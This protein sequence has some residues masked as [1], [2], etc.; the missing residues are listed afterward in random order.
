VTLPKPKAVI[1]DWD[2]TIIESWGLTLQALNKALTAMG[3]TPWSDAE[4]RRR[5]G[6]SARDLFQQ[7]FGE[8]WQEADKIFFE[9]LQYMFKKNMP[10]YPGAE[11]IFKALAAR[12]IYMAVVSNKR[13]PLLRSEAAQAKFDRYF[14][15][16][17]GAGDAAADKPDPAPVHMALEGSGIAP[18]MDVWFVGDSHTDMLC[19]ANAG[20]AAILL[21]TKTP[22]EEM[23]AKNPP[24][25]RFQ[26]H[27]DLM[28]F[29]KTDFT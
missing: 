26:K 3:A 13:G 27:S 23:L 2:D 19:A 17:V 8:R 14:G 20:C 29:I 22:P 10:V 16:V 4:A 28:E 21:E 12:K 6:P 5:A 9:S 7:M 25:R 24:H 15:K 18:G 1:F 11:D